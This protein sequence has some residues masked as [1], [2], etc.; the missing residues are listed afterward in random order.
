[1]RPSCFLAASAMYWDK[2]D[3]LGS[4]QHEPIH[5]LGRHRVAAHRRRLT[6]FTNYT[7]AGGC[8]VRGAY[9]DPNERTLPSLNA[10]TG[11]H[12]IEPMSDHVLVATAQRSTRLD[13]SSG[14]RRGGRHLDGV[15]DIVG[16]V[17]GARRSPPTEQ[18]TPKT[19]CQRLV[20]TFDTKSKQ[21]DMA[22]S[23]TTAIAL[24]RSMLSMP[25]TLIFEN[26][27]CAKSYQ[28]PLP[29]GRHQCDDHSSAGE[30]VRCMHISQTFQTTCHRNFV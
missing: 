1:M 3:F 26:D 19:T 24:R 8:R 27:H 7:V 11:H 14:A 13:P 15:L 9:N 5:D 21:C 29:Q 22:P 18:A 25:N 10:R 12:D 20:T 2:T 16:V 28:R 4:A 17:L 30:G 6:V 23:P